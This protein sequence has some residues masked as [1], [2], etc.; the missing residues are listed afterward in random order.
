MWG[1]VNKLVLKGIGCNKPQCSSH[2]SPKG[3][4]GAGLIL[5]GTA[6]VQGVLRVNLGVR[7]P[8]RLAQ[9]RV[10]ITV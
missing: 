6:G 5:P 4:R 10:T 2:R 9:S 8:P 7:S 1:D 3:A